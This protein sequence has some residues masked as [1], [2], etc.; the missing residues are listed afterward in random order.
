MTPP[1]LPP[2]APTNAVVAAT[3]AAKEINHLHAE[4][5]RLAA[6][7]CHSLDGALAAAWHAGRLLN[8]EKKRVR[9]SAGHGAWMPWLKHFF[10]GSM[11]TAHRYMRLARGTGD[12]ALLQGLSLRQAYARLGIA[13]EPKHHALDGKPSLPK[14]PAH[15]LLAGKLIRF[16]RQQSRQHTARDATDC[17]RDLAPLYAQLRPL[18]EHAARNGN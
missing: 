1:T 9:H 17:I 12:L 6:E 8:E 4:A 16:L 13:T 15:V 7:S 11:S 14:P 3:S 10:T 2:D 18:F 5:Q